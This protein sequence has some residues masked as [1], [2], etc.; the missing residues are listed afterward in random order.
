VI[1]LLLFSSNTVVAPCTF[2]NSEDRTYE[3]KTILYVLFGCGVKKDEVN[4][5]FRIL[6]NEEICYLTLLA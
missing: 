1:C 3:Y 2:Q 5:Q 6:H 4:E